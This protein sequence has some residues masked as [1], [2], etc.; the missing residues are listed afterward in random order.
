MS[1]SANARPAAPGSG[2]VLN[3]IRLVRDIRKNPFSYLLALPALVYALIF[4]YLTL[5]YIV[6][7]FKNFNYQKGIW[8]SEFVGLKNFE[9]FFRSN[10]AGLVT[11]NTVILNVLALV[12]GTALS[13][14]IALMLNEVRLKRFLKASQSVLIFPNFLS[15]VIVSYI[16]YAIFSSERGVVNVVL[17]MF[18]Q[19]GISWYSSP[20]YWRG[21][22]TT[23]KVWKSVGI[24]SVIFL[25]AITAIDDGLYEAARIDGATRIK[26]MLH[27]TLPLLAPTVCIMTLMSIGKIFYGDFQMMYTIVGDNGLLMPVTDVIDTYVYR[28]LRTTGDP[29]SSMAVGLYQALV[30]F[31]MVFGSNLLVKRMFPEGALF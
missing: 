12:F 18:G 19:K 26:Q 24:N 2:S 25:A 7:A 3:R 5:P 1:Q 17:R 4:G 14:G 29:A 9:F 30:G 11:Y 6:I 16:V 8:G 15:W 21:I 22:L 10:R 31:I 23:I 27:I 13:V 20:Q 28:A